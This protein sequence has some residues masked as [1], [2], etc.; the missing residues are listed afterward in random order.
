VIAFRAR[1]VLDIKPDADSR[2]MALAQIAEQSGPAWSGFLYGVA[3]GA[4]GVSIQRPGIGEAWTIFNPRIKAFPL[5][6]H[7]TIKSHLESIAPNLEEVWATCK[8]DGE[9]L[10]KLGFHETKD[11][12]RGTI[13]IP[14]T[15]RLFVRRP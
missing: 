2:M 8:D 3:I 13:T 9:W 12:P 1:H 11:V 5:F 6:L 14:A 10:V 15:E 4:G 7:R